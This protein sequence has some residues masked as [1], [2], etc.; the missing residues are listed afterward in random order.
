[1]RELA[2]KSFKKTVVIA[3]DHLVQKIRVKHCKSS[4]YSIYIVV[5]VYSAHA[6]HGGLFAT[7]V[8]NTAL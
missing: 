6:F 7:L 1:M 3:V 4:E 5:S 8:F 2:R